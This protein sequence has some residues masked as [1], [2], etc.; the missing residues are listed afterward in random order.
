MKQR[1]AKKKEMMEPDLISIRPHSQGWFTLMGLRKMLFASS[2][3]A[4]TPPESTK[5]LVLMLAY[6][7][8]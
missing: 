1:R 8:G 6:Q 5:T 7:L 2:L 3:S 4:T